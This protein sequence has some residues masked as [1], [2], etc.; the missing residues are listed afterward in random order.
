MQIVVMELVGLLVNLVTLDVEV[1]SNAHNHHSNE[2]RVEVDDFGIIGLR[3]STNKISFGA[4][5]SPLASKNVF[6]RMRLMN[7]I[8]VV[9]SA[10]TNS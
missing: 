10:C 3:Y 7:I 9:F 8:R 2:S 1:L 4:V 5:A 6:H